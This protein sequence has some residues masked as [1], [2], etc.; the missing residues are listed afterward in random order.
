MCVLGARREER[1]LK[2]LSVF[3]SDVLWWGGLLKRAVVKVKA[4]KVSFCT[5]RNHECILRTG[6]WISQYPEGI[7]WPLKILQVKRKEKYM[8][9]KRHFFLIDHNTILYYATNVI[10]NFLL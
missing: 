10:C 5:Q 2:T 3:P 1:C 7:C 9:P 6:Y 8:G 4:P